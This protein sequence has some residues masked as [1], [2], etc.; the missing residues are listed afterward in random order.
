MR[1]MFFALIVL[2]AIPA[3]QPTPA[4]ARD[5]RFCLREVDRFGGGPTTCYYDTF[6]QCQASASGRWATCIE[7]P[8]FAY[9]QHKVPRHKEPRRARRSHHPS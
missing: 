8:A 1:T 4:E 3:F 5:Y 2:T 9:G 7:N 6:A